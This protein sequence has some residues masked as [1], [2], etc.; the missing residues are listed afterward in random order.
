MDS[1]VEL[2]VIGGGPAG[3]SAALAAAQQGAPVTLLDAYPTPG[4]QY[5][6]QQPPYLK[7]RP[8]SHQRAGRELWEKVL[9]AG[10]TIL[11]ESQ[12]WNASPDRN[13][14]IYSPSGSS[15]LQARAVIL[16]GGAH[17]RPAAF[18]GWTLPGVIMTGAA[19]TLLYQGVLPGKRVLLAGT[20][21]LQLV[22]AKKLLDAGAQVVG[23][24]EGSTRLAWR[25]IRNLSGAWG[26]WE[27]I[28]EGLGSLM[29]LLQKRVIYRAGCGI[30]AAH[31]SNEVEGAII[32]R[33]DHNWRPIPGSQRELDCDTICIGYGFTPFTTLGKL[34]GLHH[35]WDANTS[36]DLPVR[37]G[38]LQTSQEGVYAAG[39]GANLGGAR[40]ALLEGRLAGI[41]AAAYLGYGKAKAAEALR[42]LR[43][44]LQRERAFRRMYTSLFTP[45]PGLYELAQDDTPLCRCEGVTLGDLKRAV[46]M[47]TCSIPEIKAIT[48][49][50][51]GE[52]QGRMCG[53][54]INYLI[55]RLTGRTPAEI[56]VNPARPP[57]FPVPIHA[58]AMEE[59][60]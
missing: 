49:S 52:C 17:E 13:L 56:G 21:P 16:A 9:A 40:L 20:G 24:L 11:P 31:G 44:P 58:L 59:Q 1:Q 7:Q 8:T 2:V 47:G 27:R 26:Q 12:V 45:G 34:M 60:P 30:S 39:D 14:S 4:G 28:G 51:M 19:Q 15:R 10:V 43:R 3:L 54:Q 23:V 55:A 22:V 57:V 36:T 5:Y 37:D 46:E 32:V 41:A 35:T 50:G 33:Y 53:Q 18:P 25:G 38:N 42:Q 6:R 29:T 48:R